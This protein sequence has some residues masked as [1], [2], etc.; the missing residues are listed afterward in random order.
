MHRCSRNRF[1]LAA[2]LSLHSASPAWPMDL[3]A[4]AR[5][6]QGTHAA[7][8]AQGVRIAPVSE[9]DLP[10]DEVT[11]TEPRD[12]VSR[13]SPILALVPTQDSEATPTPPVIRSPPKP[14]VNAASSTARWPL[15]PVRLWGDLAYDYRET[16]VD[17]ESAF[18]RHSVIANLNA[19]TYIY[20]PWVAIVSAGLGLALSRL[21]DG[22]LAGGDK[23]VTGY[24]RL[25]LF[26]ASRFPFEA[27][28][29]RSD[30]GT[31]V[32]VGTDQNYRLTRYGVTQRYRSETGGEQ[33]SASFD[34]FTQ[35]GTTVG[36]EIQDAL[37]LDANT[38]LRRHHELQLLGTL[39]H[40]QRVN[41]AERNDY[42]TLLAR[43]AFRPDPT[44]SLENSVNL[45]HTASRFASAE[46]ELRIFQLNSVAFWRPESQPLTVNGS[47]RLFSL[48]TG[49]GQAS[50][51]TQVVNASAGLNYTASRNLRALTGISLTDI[52]ANG[53]HNR[54]AIGTL[55]MT[56]QGDS[57]EM[58]KYRYDWFA[59]GT[60]IYTSGS[61]DRNGFSFNGLFGNSLSRGFDLGNGGALTFNIAQTLSAI[62][63]ARVEGSKQ[64]FHSGSITWNKN[65][66]ESSS[67]SFIRLSAIDSRYLDGQRETLQ[68]VNLQVS[69]TLEIG[70]DRSLSGNLT[71]QTT[72]RVSKR[73]GFDNSL[74]EGKPET[75]TSG[76]INYRHQNLFGVQ[77]LLFVSQLRLNRQELI[78]A[79]GAPSERELRS[80]ENR[81]DYGIGQLETRLLTRIAQIDGIQHW[82]MML[83]VTRRF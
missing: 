46:S 74:N 67:T 50:I 13:S 48:E 80:W 17:G 56:Y 29:V 45:T 72:R 65:E 22:A 77:R 66:P 44:I 18:T 78:Q 63:G 71:I 28:F 76:E 42:E 23:Y 43:H 68:L 35:D 5:S 49:T 8:F 34:R 59:G 21:N 52:D 36:K 82:L 62:T 26:P 1:I 38:R 27:R 55:G 4:V 32:D 40:N 83:R 10:V 2:L 39:N 15:A 79:L 31:D 61:L 33:Y 58:S 25:N 60:G 51:G 30:S 9:P 14:A 47:F 24:A 20:E 16:R 64:L 54:T 41:T 7:D 6:I 57:I 37:Q 19:S 12:P 11:E 81:L 70:R 53:Q 69:R 75:T 3:D 73:P